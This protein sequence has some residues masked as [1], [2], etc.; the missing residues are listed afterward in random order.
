MVKQLHIKSLLFRLFNSQPLKIENENIKLG[1][2]PEGNHCLLI[3][4]VSRAN[5]GEYELVARNDMGDN[6][7]KASL[8]VACEFA[9]SESIILEMKV[10]VFKVANILVPARSNSEVEPEKPLFL[11]GLRDVTV[12]ESSQLFISAPFRGNPI[13]DVQWFKNGSLLLP[14]ERIHFTCDGY[15]VGWC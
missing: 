12:D 2:T 11:H 8:T 6:S 9:S 5:A 15:K 10:L 4:K 3:K 1:T 14:N 7:S 13:P